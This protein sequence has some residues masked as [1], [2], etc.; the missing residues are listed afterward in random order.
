[1]SHIFKVIETFKILAKK[2]IVFHLFLRKGELLVNIYK[3]KQPAEKYAWYLR[4][5]YLFL[6]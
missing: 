5:L 2:V 3:S 4:I 1:M 6:K